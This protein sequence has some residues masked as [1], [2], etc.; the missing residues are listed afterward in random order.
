MGDPGDPHV[1]AVRAAVRG[2]VHV[3]DAA[4][5]AQRSLTITAEGL[6]NDGQPIHPDRGWIRR[7]APLS[8]T[9]SLDAR[10]LIGAQRTASLSALATVL[11][12]ERISWMTPVSQL[13]SAENKP[14]QYRHAQSVHV[15]VPEW[16]VT[17]DPRRAPEDSGWVT[18]PLGPGSFIDEA[19]TEQIVPT[20]P[21]DPATRSGLAGA[22][23]ILQRRVFARTHARV[24][25]VGTEVY[26]ATLP[27]DDLPTDWRLSRQA[28]HAFTNNPAADSVHA[29]ASTAAQ[30][31][32]VGYSAQDWIQ[33]TAGDWWF[34]D[35]NPAGQWLFLPEPV[36]ADITAA[37]GRFLEGQR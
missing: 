13:G 5:F 19:G 6:E 16:I 8:W 15:P 27:A 20:T 10:T 28:H 29:L 24:V 18:K 31:M 30:K 3:I 4:S 23:F 21:F 7:L 2:D 35:L 11:H 14:L 12:D 34:I 36:A 32:S 1:A 25:T 17:T 22:P 9:T 33:D 26:S 37:I